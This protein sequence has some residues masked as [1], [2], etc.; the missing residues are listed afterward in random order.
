MTQPNPTVPKRQ[1]TIVFLLTP[2]LS[3]MSL[4]SAIEPLRSLNRLAGFEAYRWRLASLDGRRIE[5][6]NGILLD[7]L[8]LDAAMVEA[9]RMFICAGIGVSDID[10]KS[11]LAALRKI[12]RSGIPVG[13]ISTGTYFLAKAGLLTER[14]CTV[15]WEIRSAFTE[16]FPE[17]NCTNRL[18]EIDGTCMTCSAGTAAIDMMLH[19]IGATHGLELMEGVANQFHH[20]RVRSVVEDQ[21]SRTL[22]YIAQLT[23][24]SQNAVA[25]M[26][27]ISS[28]RCR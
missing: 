25:L 13:A 10:A 18:Y 7:T 26:K 14:R 1:E 15:H 28:A 11:Y 4:T 9:N 3:M 2:K 27:K 21:R 19:M 22:R 12:A 5:P 16:E 8:P 24:P 6:S 20:E 23:A 17:I